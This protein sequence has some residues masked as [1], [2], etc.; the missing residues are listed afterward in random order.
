MGQSAKKVVL[1]AAIEV[2][3]GVLATIAAAN[4]IVT[5][6]LEIM[7]FEGETVSRDVD[8]ATFGGDQELHVG[9]HG[10]I[11]FK[12]EFVGS[13]TLGVVPKWEVLALACKMKTTIVA[14][15]SV[16]LTPDSEGT[17]SLSMEFNMDGNRHRLLGCRGT[18]DLIFDSQGIP[19]LEW[20]FTGL[21]VDPAS[22]APLARLSTGWPAARPVTFQDTPGVEFYGVTSGWSLKSLKFSMGNNVVYNNNPGEEDVFID[23]RD[24][25]GSIELLSRPLGDFNAFTTAKANTLGSMKIIHG[26]T[27]ATRI[28]FGSNVVQLLKPKYGK[29]KLRSTLQGDLKF[30]P[31]DT[32]DDDWFIRMA[33]A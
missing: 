20:T 26:A 8:R 3:Y 27:A 1:H 13:G 4:T 18:C 10:K 14:A 22:A 5:T 30:V 21:F 9:I 7:P 28:I 19:Y 31:S 23:D 33:A 24:S 32:G 12:T 6:G 11:K 17:T 25:K 2:T 29:D 15:T 16:E